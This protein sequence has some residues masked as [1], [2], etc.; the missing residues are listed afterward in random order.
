MIFLPEI[1]TVTS[2]WVQGKH[3]LKMEISIA[4]A[5]EDQNLTH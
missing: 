4:I 3:Q 1:G 5:K 2:V